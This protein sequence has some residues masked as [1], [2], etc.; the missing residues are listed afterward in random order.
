MSNKKT[1]L[2]I[3]LIVF[4]SAFMIFMI[5][6]SYN[7]YLR[8]TNNS[9]K[10]SKTIVK[11][12]D[13]LKIDSIKQSAII[14]TI[15]FFKFSIKCLE[16]ENE[17]LKTQVNQRDIDIPLLKKRCDSLSNR[18]IFYQLK[19]QSLKSRDTLNQD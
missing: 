13:Y 3:S 2:S 5:Y 16:D 18:L 7:Y 9:I 14:D 15:K 19:L 8:S 17:S 1:K 11:A 10:E 6:A 4:L 12:D